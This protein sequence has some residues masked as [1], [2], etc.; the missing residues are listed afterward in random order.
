MTNGAAIA[1]TMIPPR[2]FFIAS[3]GFSPFIKMSN[4][5]LKAN[6]PLTPPKIF[7]NGPNIPPVLAIDGGG[8]GPI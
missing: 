5:V 3:I 2:L 6:V 1:A 8:V 7:L 4:N